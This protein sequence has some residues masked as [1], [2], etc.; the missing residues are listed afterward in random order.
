MTTTA[1]PSDDR[2]RDFEFDLDQLLLRIVLRS[3]PEWQRPDGSRPSCWLEIQQMQ[4][5]ADGV[6][7]LDG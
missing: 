1:Q 4:A 3:H 5:R 2:I 6:D 7:A